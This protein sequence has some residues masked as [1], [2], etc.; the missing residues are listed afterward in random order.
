MINAEHSRLHQLFFRNFFR[1][2]LWKDFHRMEIIGEYYDRGLP[3]LIIG[4]HI[5][6][7]DGFIPYELNR[8][9]FKRRFH[10]MMLEEQLQKIKFFRRLGAFSIDP[11]KRSALQSVNIASDILKIKDNLLVLFP[12]GE[13]QSQFKEDII[14]RKGWFR[15]LKNASNPVHVLFMAN[16][17]DYLS[18]RKPTLYMYLESY[19]KT[20]NFVFNDLCNCY[21]SFHQR[22]LENQKRLQ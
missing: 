4:N 19:S 5:S 1:Y 11:G 21:N 16:R 6:W 17:T 20:D 10:L 3:L 13:I 22:S 9:I 18:H 7:W 15:I 2:I 12:Q 8:R 14:F